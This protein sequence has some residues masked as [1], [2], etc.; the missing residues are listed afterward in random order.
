[1]RTFLINK[2]LR[3]GKIHNIQLNRPRIGRNNPRQIYNLLLC[4]LACIRRRMKIDGLHT[5][6]PLGCKIPRNRTV[7]SSGEQKH[8][9]PAGSDR[10]S[11][12]P[13]NNLGIDIGLIPD[14]HHD[15]FHGSAH[16]DPAARKSFQQ[17]FS[18]SGT[19]LRRRDRILLIRAL[20]LHLEGKFPIAVYLL[21]EVPY[22]FSQIIP[23]GV[24]NDTDR[25]NRR[26]A[27]YPCQHLHR[28][29]IVI[30]LRTLDKDSAL[31]SYNAIFSYLIKVILN[32]IP[33]GI[34]KYPAVLAL[35]PDF[36]IF[37]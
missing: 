5:D 18:H 3:I 7:N 33:Q 34:L 4:P 2:H 13:R 6:A 11:A 37:N 17:I 15:P 28:L 10:H 16:I 1:M 12:R 23:L 24:L 22:P 9:P 30:I 14:L 35:Q 29:V 25:T 21:N 31:L 20:G 36:R 19:D 8:R 32:L 26:Y 27:E